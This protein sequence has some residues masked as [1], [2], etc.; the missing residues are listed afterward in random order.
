MK[1]I[2]D[3]VHWKHSK[4][5]LSVL[6]CFGFYVVG[7]K[8]LLV[9]VILFLGA[10]YLPMPRIFRSWTSRL[11]VSFLF[12]M[13][14][15][16]V[17][18]T[19]QFFIFPHSNF[20][21]LAALLVVA[22]AVLLWLVPRQKL[23][24][25]SYFD[26]SDASALLITVFFLLPFTPLLLG[27]NGIF[28]I[29]Q[30]GSIQAI[31]ATN[32]YAGIAEITNAQHLTYAPN[33]YYPKGFHIAT[34]FIQNTLFSNQYS[35]GWRGNV[36]L[37]FT[38]YV[39][40]A[41]TMAYGAYYLC[42]SLFAFSKQRVLTNGRRLLVAF[43]LGPVLTL[44]Y[45]L[46]LVNE[47]FLNY[48][49]VILT[50]LV[51]LVFL[52]EL[53]SEQKGKEDDWVDAIRDDTKR[54]QIVAY[55]LLIFGASA[56]WPLLIPPLVITG[57]LFVLPPSL[58]LG[59]FFREL[60]SWKGLPLIVVFL[61]QLVPIYFQVKYS[62]IS[63]KQGINATGGLQSFHP[64]VLLAGAVVLGVTVWSK[65]VP[66]AYKKLLV[67]IY[68]P[69]LAFVGLLIM[70]Q[71]FSLGEIRYYVIKSSILL[72]VLFLVLSITVLVYAYARSA[73]A[74]TLY[75]FLLPAV[76]F[77]IT[78]LLITTLPNPLNDDR[79]LFRDASGIP[80][81]MLFEHDVSIYTKLGKAGQIRHFNST[82]LHYDGVKQKIFGHQQA[83]YW[84]NMMQ[85]DS[86]QADF[87]ALNCAGFVYS[88]LAFGSFTDGEQQALISKVRE[89]AMD[90]KNQGLPYYIVTDSGSVSKLTD[91]FGDVAKIV[92]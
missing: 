89:C 72:E 52:V 53:V 22:M 42:I 77:V 54:W 85:Y 5:A 37:Y 25:R 50:I 55:M 14:L 1:N 83:Q 73:M 41:G 35:L 91:L 58:R 32:H 17:V 19:V 18:A 63:G 87:L 69:L 51:A 71:Y 56:S 43:C 76:P 62:G 16:Q 84:A 4:E 33:Y 49:Y 10:K 26:V 8:F 80:K 11:F 47:G 88:N 82:L 7:I 9:P 30:I 64:Y 21:M 2:Q 79:E 59:T 12:L 75:A 92:Y 24:K 74:H 67:N 38:Q 23:E 90:A 36:L 86:S 81:P 45:L 28:H 44:L 78:I 66:D 40:F 48:Y 39:F 60:L 46:P 29:A 20:I 65:Q 34:G 70:Y 3:I 15:L 13:V 68:V 31:D 6:I 27:G 57:V 61:L